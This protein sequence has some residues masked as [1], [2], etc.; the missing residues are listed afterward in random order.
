M[1]IGLIFIIVGAAFLFQ[2]L[3]YIPA[4]TWGVIWPAL[5]MA[6]GLRLL[7]KK[8]RGGF[9]WEEEFGWRKKKSKEK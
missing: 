6:L 4:S 2:N 8:S 7:F 5:L 9:F 1:F 3:G